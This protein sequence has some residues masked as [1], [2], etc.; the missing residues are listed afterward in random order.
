MGDNCVNMTRLSHRGWSSKHGSFV[1][2]IQAVDSNHQFGSS[3]NA[4]QMLS[5]A[6]TKCDTTWWLYFHF[7]S[8]SYFFLSLTFNRAFG[9]ICLFFLKCCFSDEI[10]IFCNYLAPKHLLIDLFLS[11]VIFIV[12][13]YYHSSKV[14]FCLELF[15]M[16]VKVI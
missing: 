14:N 2:S 6:E 15:L 5:M 13:F 16:F 12:I 10:L 8:F 3:D 11:W 4:R 7:R 1:S 9:W